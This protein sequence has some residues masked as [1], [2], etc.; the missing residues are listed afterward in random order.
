MTRS[1]VAFNADWMTGRNRRILKRD[2][3]LTLTG[4]GGLTNRI[5]ASALG[6]LKI[7]DVS[8]SRDSAN[9]VIAAQPSYDGTFIVLSVTT[10]GTPADSSA[11]IRMVVDGL[12]D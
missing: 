12:I 7:V 3:T 1:Q 8:A 2:V 9:N 4:Q 6:L 10:A 11:T 5:V